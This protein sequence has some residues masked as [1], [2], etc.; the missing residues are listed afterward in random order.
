LIAQDFL[1]RFFER[2]FEPFLGT[3]A[4]FLRASDKPI[5]IACFRLFTFL[6]ERPLRSV[7]D[8]RFFIARP[9]FFDAPFEYRR[10]FAFFAILL[11]LNLQTCARAYCR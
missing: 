4:P 2:F 11:I 5:A 1:D 10:F 8:L 3:L 7:P 9:T 6:P